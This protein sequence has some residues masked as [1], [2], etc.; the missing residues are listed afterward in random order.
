MPLLRTHTT[1]FNVLLV[2]A[3]GAVNQTAWGHLYE[4]DGWNCPQ[5]A[6]DHCHL[7]VQMME[8][9][10]VADI[11]ILESFYGNGFRR[12]VIPAKDEVEAID[13]AVLE[14]ALQNATRDSRKGPYHKIRHGSKLLCLIDPQSVRSKAPHC[15]EPFTMLAHKIEADEELF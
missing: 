12:G 10:F 4:R 1:A 14:T 7:M 6:D 11:D 13:K 5:V 8:A 15:E 2:D 3:E 9:W